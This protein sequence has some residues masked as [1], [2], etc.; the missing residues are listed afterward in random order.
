VNPAGHA[1]DL[2]PIEVAAGND[3]LE[4]PAVDW[5]GSVF[6]VVW[7]DGT[8]V[9]G[10]RLGANAV[11][12]DPAPFTILPGEMPDVAALGD[13]FL[14]VSSHEAPHEIRPIK[15][16][17][18]RGSDG[19][20]LD[21]SPILI[22]PSFSAWPRAAALGTRWL[23]VWEQYPSHDNPRSNIYANFVEAGGAA[24]GYFSVQDSSIPSEYRPDIAT[25]GDYALIVWGDGRT[26]PEY[27]DVYGRRVHADGFFLDG[28]SIPIATAANE[29]WDPQVAW[30]GT[31]FV[32]E[33][34]DS[35]DDDQYDQ[36]RGD[37]WG[38]LLNAAGQ[39]IDP[40][41]FAVFNE[42]IPE[43]QPALAART[44]TALLTGAIFHPEAPYGA[45]RIGL[46]VLDPPVITSVADSGRSPRLS[47]AASPNPAT[48]PVSLLVDL[49][50]GGSAEAV[51]FDATGRE[52]RRLEPGMLPAGASVISWDGLDAS[53]RATARGIYLARVRAAGEERTVK[54]VRR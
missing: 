21:S 51:V 42:A 27:E 34:W 8:T 33:H 52:V 54:L 45:Y 23:V 50:T 12:I 26:N 24:A 6:L 37:I 49:P 22:G 19:A 36:H 28:G 29:Q 14:V 40:S 43:I 11:P 2:E 25:A 32:V 1:I 20:V 3:A 17:R 15:G 48:G 16:A 47:L 31:R 38:T 18:V 30:D 13:V 7:E 44:G 5:N 35:R 9:R 46:R 53:G 10:R 39:P 4:N 41:G